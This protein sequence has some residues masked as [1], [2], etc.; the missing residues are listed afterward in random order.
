MKSDIK[1]NVDQEKNNVP[2]TDF[3]QSKENILN[4]HMDV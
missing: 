4:S 2:K 3:A 1:K